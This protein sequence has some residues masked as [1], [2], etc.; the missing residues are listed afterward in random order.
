MP[1]IQNA[2]SASDLFHIHFKSVDGYNISQRENTCSVVRN[3]KEETL[4]N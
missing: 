1:R 3:D 4:A 2:V